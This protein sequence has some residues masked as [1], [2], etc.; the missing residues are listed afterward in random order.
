MSNI[1]K[2]K[3]RLFSIRG[4][5]SIILCMVAYYFV[6]KVEKGPNYIRDLIITVLPF[7]I[8]AGIVDYIA[9]KKAEG[10]EENNEEEINDDNKESWKILNK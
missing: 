9:Y 1:E 4:I 10:I 3:K 7:I 5:F 2:Y 6:S 8:I